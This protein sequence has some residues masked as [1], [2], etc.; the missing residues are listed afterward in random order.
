MSDGRT[1]PASKGLYLYFIMCFICLRMVKA[2][3]KRK[4]TSRMGQ[5][6]G[7]SRNGKRVARSP[8]RNDR[9]DSIL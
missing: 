9:V 4:Y 6:T 3:R 5:Y 1:L 8:S 2:K 7:T